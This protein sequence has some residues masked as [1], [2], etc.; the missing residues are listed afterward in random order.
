MTFD[1]KSKSHCAVFSIQAVLFIS[2]YV[3]VY[4]AVKVDS[5]VHSPLGE[6]TNDNDDDSNDKVMTLIN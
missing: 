5:T 1:K 3:V 4:H 6:R 2:F